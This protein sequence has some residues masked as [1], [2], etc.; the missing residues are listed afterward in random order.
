MAYVKH[1]GAFGE[2]SP[3]PL[4]GLS[5]A[6]GT[7]MAAGEQR[8]RTK[9]MGQ[10][11]NTQ[12]QESNLK[13]QSLKSELAKAERTEEDKKRKLAGDT[14]KRLSLRLMGKSPAEQQTI[15]E[16]PS[17]KQLGK[18]LI[19][20]ALPESYD[21]TTQR[22]I[23]ERLEWFPKTEAEKLNFQRQSEELKAKLKAGQPMTMSNLITWER[24]VILAKTTMMIPD[25]EADKQLETINQMRNQMLSKGEGDNALTPALGGAQTPGAETPGAQDTGDWWNK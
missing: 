13:L 1:L 25:E 6:I 14:V 19:K 18:D 15:L 20:D 5:E 7:G 3:S 16:S 17:I 9:I 12:A 24:N 21:T 4:S 22:I 2:P 11:A 8:Q 23:P 10:Q